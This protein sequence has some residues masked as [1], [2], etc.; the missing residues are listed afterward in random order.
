MPNNYKHLY[1][2]MRKLVEK[3]QD[4][5]V[6]GLR[7]VIEDLEN[8]RVEV[9]RCK[10]CKY[11]HEGTDWCDKHSHFVDSFGSFCHPD[12]SLEW[13]MFDEDYFCK[14]GERKDNV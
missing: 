9:V 7:K 6:P 5:V 1:E 4:E 14:D 8:S 11:W 12:E 13:K 10:D 3:Y 2:Q